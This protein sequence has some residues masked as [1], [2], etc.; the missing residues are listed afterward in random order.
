MF[1]GGTFNNWDPKRSPLKEE[2]CGLFGAT[3]MLPKGTH[4]YK[5][6]VNGEWR[7]DPN[8]PDWAPNSLGTL[9]SRMQVG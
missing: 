8:C 6:V 9:N 1:V 4:E 5:F 2:Q 3:L 7:C